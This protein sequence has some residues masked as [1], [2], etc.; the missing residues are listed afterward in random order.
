[1]LLAEILLGVEKLDNE[2]SAALNF[3][4]HYARCLGH[5]STNSVF[6]V[7]LL[8]LAT[9]FCEC[10]G[11]KK[12]RSRTQRQGC[13][14]ND[15]PTICQA[16]RAG[17]DAR[18]FVIAI[19]REGL[20]AVGYGCP[21][22]PFCPSS[23]KRGSLT[24]SMVAL[25]IAFS[26][27]SSVASISQS[28][29]HSCPRRPLFLLTMSISPGRSSLFLWMAI[30]PSGNFRSCGRKRLNILVEPI[31]VDVHRGAFFFLSP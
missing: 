1:M 19:I 8:T 24:E 7:A 29:V 5:C 18:Q 4:C 10:V 12:A 13:R 30:F 26:A 16:G 28:A 25:C 17:A 20:P 9:F 23:W 27:L 6:C 31:K 22:Q 15:I 2:S 11:R 14:A 3:L 21:V